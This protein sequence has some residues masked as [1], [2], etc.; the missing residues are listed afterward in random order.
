MLPE[1]S[2]RLTKIIE[3]KRLKQKLEQDLSAV[4]AELQTASTRF[5]VLEAQL[6]KEQVDVEK[7]ENLSLTGLF[8]SF[9]GSKEEQLDKERQELLSAQV[10]YQHTKK[11]VA[12]LEQDKDALARQLGDLAGVEADYERLLSEKDDL[13]RLSNQPVAR[14]LMELSGQVAD[15]NSQL[16]DIAEAISAGKVVLVGMDEIKVSLQSAEGWGL[17]DLLGGGL[18]TTAVK[19]SRINDARASV[20]D[21]QKNMRHF[22]RELADLQNKIDLKIDVSELA[23][24]ADFF[25]D[26]LI[27]DWLVQSKI[28]ASL[29]QSKKARKMIV[30]TLKE[31]ENLK[32]NTQ[33]QR[34][35]LQEKQALLIEQA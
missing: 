30:K 28:Q 7:L 35:A 21:V 10:K 33:R 14:E 8:Y 1:L 13:L 6:I 17:W 18:L 15:L 26:G 32:K 22:K 34:A 5:A 24:F 31:I 27:I 16:K 25:F 2:T 3:Q 23:S 11:Q 29:E 9:L 12:F 20:I 4:T 19:H